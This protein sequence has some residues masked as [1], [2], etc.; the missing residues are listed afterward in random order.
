MS[1]FEKAT[2][3]TVRQALI[4]HEASGAMECAYTFLTFTRR[5]TAKQEASEK[6][7]RAKYNERQIFLR[8]VIRQSL[9]MSC[10]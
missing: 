4:E 2:L 8:V 7:K 6:A 1:I 3:F 5:R 9:G 10:E